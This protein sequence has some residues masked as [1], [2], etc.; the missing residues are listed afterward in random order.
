MNVAA[1]QARSSQAIRTGDLTP[2][3]LLIIVSLGYLLMGL[4]LRQIRWIN[5]DEGAHI[6]DAIL[7][8]DGK[9]PV[10]DFPSRQPLYTLFLAMDLAV[11][12]PS[13]AA[14]RVAPLIATILTG[15]GVYFFTRLRFERSYALAGSLAYLLLPLTLTFA[16]VVKMEP[17]ALALGTVAAICCVAALSGDRAPAWLFPAGLLIA[18]SFYVRES[19]AYAL[20]FASLGSLVLF[21]PPKYASRL[22]AMMWLFGGVLCGFLLAFG[23]FAPH[24]GLAGYFKSPLNPMSKAV[25]AIQR[26]FGESF[27]QQPIEQTFKDV[28]LAMNSVEFL[29]FGSLLGIGSIVLPSAR[30]RYETDISAFCALWLAGLII[31]YSIRGIQAAFYPSYAREFTVPA[32]VLTVAGVRWLWTDLKPYLA[33]RRFSSSRVAATVAL[34]L[35]LVAGQ[36]AVFQEARFVFFISLL[37]LIAVLRLVLRTGEGVNAPSSASSRFWLYAGGILCAGLV[38]RAVMSPAKRIVGPDAYFF[39]TVA[40]LAGITLLAFRRTRLPL[41]ATGRATGLILL[42]A[43]TLYALPSAGYMLDRRYDS[44]WSPAQLSGVTRYLE[45][46]VRPDGTVLSGANIWPIEAGRKLFGDVTHPLSLEVRPGNLTRAYRRIGNLLRE[47]PPDAIVLD[48]FTEKTYGVHWNL[49]DLIEGNYSGGENVTLKGE[50][51]YP[52]VIYLRKDMA[53]ADISGPD[54]SDTRWLLVIG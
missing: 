9:V 23:L 24:M 28:G 10:V 49:G 5:P 52:L 41:A 47:S 46:R 51:V 21:K 2:I 3:I 34:Q 35:V 54:D 45:Q 33:G 19:T 42:V 17:F 36:I 8:L 50:S 31:I 32:I 22:P 37:L 27:R 40:A 44:V 25:W 26:L 13:L 48:G 7:L 39:L 16:T 30:S 29:V 18:A 15:V 53:M 4:W 11:L 6:A 20:G 38:F 14:A 43:I 12:G 1:P